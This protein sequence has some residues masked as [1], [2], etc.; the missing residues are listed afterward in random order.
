ML[1]IVLFAAIVLL[2]FFVALLLKRNS[3]LE[4]LLEST[5]FSKS[6]QSSRYGKAVEQWIPFAESFPLDASNFR[7]IGSPVDGVSFEDD[8][9]VFCEF[10][11]ADSKLS[12]KQKR[13]KELARQ[14]KVEWLEFR[15]R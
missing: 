9:I 12:E 5:K 4:E 7:F 6:S 14:G 2:L 15:I 1:E 8:R 13:I 3:E 11:A 10:K